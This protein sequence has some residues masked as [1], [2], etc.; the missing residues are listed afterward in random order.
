MNLD[1]GATVYVA[2]HRGLAG[3]AIWRRLE[4]GGFARL[5]GRTSADLDL[6]DREA[7]FDFFRA[8]RPRLLVLAAARVGG[9]LANDSFPG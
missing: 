2:G 8:T 9:I 3:S 6:R 7:V 4:A 5:V 1:K